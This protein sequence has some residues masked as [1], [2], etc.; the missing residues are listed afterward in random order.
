MDIVPCDSCRKPAHGIYKIDGKPIIRC[1]DCAPSMEITT[2]F[3][4]L[5]PQ[6]KI[7]GE[8]NENFR[9]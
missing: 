8:H 9:Y 3:T 4:P 1:L 2:G 7:K 5:N 6:L